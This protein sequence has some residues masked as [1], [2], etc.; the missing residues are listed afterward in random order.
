L[1]VGLPNLFVHHMIYWIADICITTSDFCHVL[2]LIS[3][4]GYFFFKYPISEKEI[5]ACCFIS[6]F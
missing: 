3:K 5:C 2:H 6:Y 1:D 4:L